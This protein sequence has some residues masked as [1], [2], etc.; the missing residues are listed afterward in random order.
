MV[1]KAVVQENTPEFTQVILRV[2]QRHRLKPP[3]GVSHKCKDSQ[4]PLFL[5]I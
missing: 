5:Y 2:L 3:V 1:S 4:R